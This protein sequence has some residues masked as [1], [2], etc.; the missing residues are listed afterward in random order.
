MISAAKKSVIHVARS[1]IGMDESVYRL[2]LD[3]V[4][5]VTS[6]SDLNEDGFTR[7]MREF[8]SLG[9]RSTKGRA[10]KQQR[11]FMAT[12]A[13]VGKIRSLWRDY[14]GH[15]DE[16]SLN[17]WLRKHGGVDHV[18]FLEAYKAGKMIA[19]LLRM[20]DYKRRKT[21]EAEHG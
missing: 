6:S 16:P 4:A 12:A 1:Q 13:Q 11:E 18:R 2:M 5:G 21:R 17:K 3:R 10:Q 8:E 20:R 19:V 9:F 7:V 15:D 14:L